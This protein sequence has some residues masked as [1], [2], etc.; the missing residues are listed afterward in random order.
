MAGEENGRAPGAAPR[1]RGRDGDR[2]GRHHDHAQTGERQRSQQQSEVEATRQLLAAQGLAAPA[3]ARARQQHQRTFNVARP[4]STSTTLMIQKRTIT[5]G[6][7]Q[8][9]SSKWWWIGAM[10][11]DAPAGMKLEADLQHDRCGSITNTPPMISSTTSWRTITADAAQ[12]RADRQRA[13][14]AHEDLRR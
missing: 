7:G 2:A 11:E 1:P 10:R 8:P 14:V 5:R 4:T 12:C 9:Q 6:S 13:D 3:S